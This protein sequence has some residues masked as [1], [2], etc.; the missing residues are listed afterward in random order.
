M[1]STFGCISLSKPEFFK[2]MKDGRLVPYI[3]KDYEKAERQLGVHDV[4]KFKQSDV[5]YLAC[6]PEVVAY[7]EMKKK[8]GEKLPSISQPVLTRVTVRGYLAG[9]RTQ[10]TIV[11]RLVL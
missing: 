9:D 4:K 1:P 5:V 2:K 8:E 3:K 6:D 11:P 10:K 7:K